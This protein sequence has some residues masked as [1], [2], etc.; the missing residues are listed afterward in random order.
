MGSDSSNDKG[1]EGDLMVIAGMDMNIA[2]IVVGG[3]LIM[4]LVEK[5]IDSIWRKTVDTD[6]VTQ[7]HC[8][9][10]E[11]NRVDDLASLKREV[12]E[13]FGVIKGMLMALV[14]K[15]EI[16]TEELKDLFGG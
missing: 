16:S 5:V 13:N 11:K 7:S 15:R 10:C 8:Q 4:R 2:F 6:Y 9:S 3:F 12:R 1:G 14:M